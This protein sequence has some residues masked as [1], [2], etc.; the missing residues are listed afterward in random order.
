MLKREVLDIVECVEIHE[1]LEK[2]SDQGFESLV[3]EKER[4]SQELV[5]KNPSHFVKEQVTEV[6]CCENVA[7]DV[8]EGLRFEKSVCHCSFVV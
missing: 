3:F 5:R 8:M 2:G 7:L 4:G 1:D 6:I